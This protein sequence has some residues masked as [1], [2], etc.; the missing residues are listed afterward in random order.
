MTPEK[1]QEREQK[2]HR[3][4]NRRLGLAA[5]LIGVVLLVLA[6]MPP[7]FTFGM[8]VTLLVVGFGMSLAY[9]PR[10]IREKTEEDEDIDDAKRK[11]QAYFTA[12]D[13]P[14]ESDSDRG[15]D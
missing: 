14:P 4:S 11:M 15:Q 3:S 2:R 6:M 12:A 1:W 7:A 5:L 8:A 10:R 13:E 9:S